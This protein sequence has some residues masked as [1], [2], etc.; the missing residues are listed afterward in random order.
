MP[1]WSGTFDRPTYKEVGSAD[2]VGNID[3]PNFARV[4]LSLTPCRRESTHV[5]HARLGGGYFDAFAV[6]AAASAVLI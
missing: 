5:L 4:I 1:I 6:V 3:R 2:L